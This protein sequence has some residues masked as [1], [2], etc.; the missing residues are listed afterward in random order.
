[1]AYDCILI[2]ISVYGYKYNQDLQ[3]IQKYQSYYKLD[4]PLLCLLYILTGLLLAEIPILYNGYTEKCPSVN[5][6]AFL[7]SEIMMV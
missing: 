4:V 2:V 3:N 6:G 1:M 7:F 5:V